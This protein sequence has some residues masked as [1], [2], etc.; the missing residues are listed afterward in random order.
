MGAF[1]EWNGPQ[2][3]GGASTEAILKLVKEYQT[4]ATELHEHMQKTVG[5]SEAVSSGGDG[6]LPTIKTE[7]FVH[8]IREVLNEILLKLGNKAD[9]SVQAT[10]Q[11]GMSDAST[12]IEELDKQLNAGDSCLTKKL[13]ANIAKTEE[14][15]GQLN[16]GDSCLTKKLGANIAKTEELD[17]QL[18]VGDSCLT[19]LVEKLDEKVALLDIEG[20]AGSN[21]ETVALLKNV[22]AT[23]R[24]FVGAL[25]I[26]STADFTRWEKVT[27]QYAGTGAANDTSTYGLYI[28]GRLSSDWG[29]CDDEL[30]STAKSCRV[31]LKYRNSKPFD[32]II[33]V[34]LADNEHA[35]IQ[36]L[37]SKTTT[38]YWKGLRF[39]VIHATDTSDNKDSVYLALSTE[40]ERR[41][42]ELEVLIAGTNF[43]PGGKVSKVYTRLAITAPMP[44]DSNAAI[45][46]AGSL[47]LDS[48]AI[49]V[50]KD[51]DDVPFM[52]SATYTDSE[53][54]EQKELL[55]GNEAFRRLR[56]SRRPVLLGEDGVEH[57]F[58]TD[59]DID[60]LAMLSVGSI[61]QWA[62]FE[63]IRD[64]NNVVMRRAINVPEGWY[65]TDGTSIPVLGNE[66]LAE[67]GILPYVDEDHTALLLPLQDFS[68]IKARSKMVAETNRDGTIPTD[69]AE[70]AR[71]VRALKQ[72]L[73]ILKERSDANDTE[74]T[75][76]LAKDPEHESGLS[77]AIDAEKERAEGEEA[78]IKEDTGNLHFLV[79]TPVYEHE[80]DLP[81]T[82]LSKDRVWQ[83]GDIAA[84]IND[85]GKYIKTVKS[86]D[87][88]GFIEWE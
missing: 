66:A 75:K 86:I 68:I 79:H 11:K 57:P 35:C 29:D 71:L 24:Y 88:N 28:I 82:Y 72:E 10:L 60:S 42:E 81:R 37:V 25:H 3:N 31:Y 16:A 27:M 20:A 33:D 2:G 84:I 47:T 44:L 41:P 73:D 85:T 34:A 54:T 50:L 1:S 7:G 21:K 56:L 15:D 38:D 46:T 83:V 59:A 55:I 13:G 49:S 18:N 64:G 52:Q 36:A 58:V 63:E 23:S 74:H 22:V 5:F 87:G 80:S 6:E 77:K 8:G 65:A 32:A 19:A 26:K 43:M 48:I 30:G 12:K 69:P 78:L 9:A 14:L 67:K 4:L 70:L 53:G 17:K 62:A 61:I 39:H 45:L 51:K 76:Q 40:E